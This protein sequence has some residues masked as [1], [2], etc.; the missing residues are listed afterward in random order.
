[1]GFFYQFPNRDLHQKNS[2]D[3]K[4]SQTG[5]DFGLTIYLNIYQEEYLFTYFSDTAGVKVVIHD[6]S[7]MPTPW[8][9]GMSFSPGF[10]YEIAIKRKESVHLSKPYSKSKCIDNESYS[11]ESCLLNC[12]TKICYEKCDCSP[13]SIDNKRACTLSDLIN[14]TDYDMKEYYQGGCQCLPAC[15]TVQY[16][17]V[18][19]SALYPSDLTFRRLQHYGLNTSFEDFPKNNLVLKIYF[20]SMEYVSEIQ[21]PAITWDQLIADIGGQ[22]GLFLGASFLTVIEAFQLLCK[23]ICI[24]CGRKHQNK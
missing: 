9:N 7:I 11:F 24:F 20:E 10:Q 23:C 4:I 15:T 3:F 21:K 17:S 18:I 1:M 13:L 19:S 14:C 5:P 2:S 8:L 16:T 12:Q 22:L 6:L